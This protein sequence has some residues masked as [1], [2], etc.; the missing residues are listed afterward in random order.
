MAAHH[1]TVELGSTAT[2]LSASSVNVQEIQLE[3]ETG[4]ADMKVGGASV[5]ATDYGRTLEAGPTKSI[6][7]SGTQGQPLNLNSVY[8]FG[9]A[10]QK[11]H[12]LYT[13]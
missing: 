10:T 12:V 5:T 9:T 11:V 4:N 3:S 2:R 6:K 13:G 8:L 1:L 7:M